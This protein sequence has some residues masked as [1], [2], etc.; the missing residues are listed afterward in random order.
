MSY[1]C[2]IL[3][4][5]VSE[6][7]CRLTTFQVT[8]P[9]LILAEVNTHK[10]LS[11][12]SASSRAVP[13]RKQ[14]ERIILEPFIPELFG[15]DQPGMQAGPPLT[16]AQHEKAV[17]LRLQTR[18]F[19]VLQ[20]LREIS[21]PALVRL[22]LIEHSGLEST[23][24]L[25]KVLGGVTNYLDILKQ[26]KVE[27]FGDHLGIHKQDA[28]RMLEPLMWHTAIITGT[29]WWNF[30]ALRTHKDA[31]PE[32]QKIALM[33]L[34]AYRE[35]KPKLLTPGQWHKPLFHEDEELLVAEKG[36]VYT[37]QLSS[38]R[39]AR[40]SYLTHD[41]RRDLEADIQLY[42]RLVAGGHMS[43]TEHQ[44][45]PMTDKEYAVSSYSG[46]FH[47]FTQFRKTLPNEQDF[48][49]VLEAQGLSLPT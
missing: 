11:K 1:E 18:D 43:P 49:Q 15:T 45:T 12:N 40:V 29:D 37:V 35:S 41:G 20:A 47:G 30:F 17:R 16:G 4:D 48:S 39:C 8:F 2:S 34:R 42:E 44:G 19:L 38:G 14:L 46:N 6:R 21:S 10:M 26:G 32:F 27:P 9:R 36:E 7:G 22:L 24:K 5:S 25:M 31:Q 28:N 33:M 23:T 13:V 3:A